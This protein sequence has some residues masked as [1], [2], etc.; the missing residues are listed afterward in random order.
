MALEVDLVDF[1]KDLKNVIAFVVVKVLVALTLGCLPGMGWAEPTSE[2][3]PRLKKALEKFPEADANKDGVLTLS[4]AK[5]YRDKVRPSEETPE[6][7]GTTPGA[8]TGG[9]VS[10]GPGHNCLFIGHSF[11]VPVART[12]ESFPAKYGITGHRQQFVFSG[13]ASGAPGSLWKS[14]KRASIEKILQ[15]GEIDLLGMTYYDESNS[16]FEAYQRWVDVAIEH[17]PKTTF[18]I[19]LPWAKHGARESWD[20]YAKTVETIDGRLRA[21]VDRLRA[22][23]PKNKFLYAE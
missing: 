10:D 4:E 6:A 7:A 20:K 23:Y 9:A 21:T 8:N 22:A 12:F 2:T 3:N 11:F 15:S 13:G 17:N 14:K 16:S 5:A 1:G 19:G 18:F